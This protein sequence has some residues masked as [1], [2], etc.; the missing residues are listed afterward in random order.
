MHF[1]VKN[2]QMICN[3]SSW[4]RS[5]LLRKRRNTCSLRLSSLSRAPRGPHRR[6]RRRRVLLPAIFLRSGLR[7]PACCSWTREG[8]AKLRRVYCG[9]R[10]GRYQQ[11]MSPVGQR[12]YR[13][14]CHVV[15]TDTERG[16]PFKPAN[17]NNQRFLAPLKHEKVVDYTRFP[18]SRRRDGG[19][20]A[21]VWAGLFIPQLR[22]FHNGAH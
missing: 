21:C 10:Q 3:Y 20:R 6:H 12:H 18:P 1:F 5:G 19:E 15:D 11:Q 4:E 8:A 2:A 16:F 17:T 9:S 22:L 14:T 13:L 7:S